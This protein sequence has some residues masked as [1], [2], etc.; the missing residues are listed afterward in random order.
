MNEHKLK[1]IHAFTNDVL[2][3]YDAVK[4]AQLIQSKEVSVQEVT[5]AAVDRAKKINPHINA[6][7]TDYFE[8]ALNDPKFSINRQF[9]GVPFFFKDNTDYAGMPSHHGSK[10][11]RP[12]NAA[13]NPK[14]SRQ[15]LDQGFV[16][17]GK[18]TLPEFGLNASTEFKDG[19]ATLNPWHTE[20]SCGASS[21]GSAALVAAGVIPIAHA[22][23]GGGSIRIPAACCGLIGLKPTRGRTF[24]S[25]ASKSLPINIISEGVVTRSVRDTAH[26][27]AG[28]ERS[29]QNPKLPAIGLIEHPSGRANCASA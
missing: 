23:D 11:I 28:M 13:N 8:Q 29:F 20:Y 1:R 7:E 24:G 21:G 9:S 6:I 25:D 4:I 10:A 15:L 27:F 22:N 16:V 17:L 12:G 18:S 5:Q 14:L 19:S 2:A 3:D 26:F